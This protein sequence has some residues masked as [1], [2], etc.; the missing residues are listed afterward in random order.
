MSLTASSIMLWFLWAAY[1]LMLVTEGESIAVTRRGNDSM[2]RK[3]DYDW[4][5]GV[6]G[7]KH[8]VG[9]PPQSFCLSGLLF[10]SWEK[11]NTSLSVVLLGPVS[12]LP[13][14]YLLQGLHLLSFSVLH[15]H[16]CLVSL[17]RCWKTSPY[18]I[19]NMNLSCLLCDSWLP[20]D[21]GQLKT[22]PGSLHLKLRLNHLVITV[23]LRD[24]KM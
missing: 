9:F 24:F 15:Y 16:C 19:G 7:R 18:R 5:T 11:T 20:V 10:N 17:H 2:N 21:F 6:W 1:W 3:Q 23:S 22:K 12:F 13:S 8:L 14:V 4:S